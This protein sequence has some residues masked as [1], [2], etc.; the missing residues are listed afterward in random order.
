MA[1]WQ[2]NLQFD[3]EESMTA[4]A[5]TAPAAGTKTTWKLDP[6]HSTVEFS[7]KHL[8]ITTVKDR[9]TDVEK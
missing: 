4:T 7:A 9:I 8:M 5:Q 1:N 3:Q 2:F 6:S